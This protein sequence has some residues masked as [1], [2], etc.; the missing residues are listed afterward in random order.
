M[1]LDEEEL[2]DLLVRLREAKRNIKYEKRA[3]VAYECYRM[4]EALANAYKAEVAN[5]I[6]SQER[7][8]A[9]A[10]KGK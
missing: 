7:A 9:K 2:N 1:A 8:K 4:F 6:R 3:A 10:M 5:R